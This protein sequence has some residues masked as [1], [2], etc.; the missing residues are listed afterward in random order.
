MINFTRIK[1]KIKSFI[2]NIGL[3]RP[4]KEYR[5][6]LRQSMIRIVKGGYS[7]NQFRR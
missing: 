5:R 4:T 1:R 6:W 7:P 2:S 3:D